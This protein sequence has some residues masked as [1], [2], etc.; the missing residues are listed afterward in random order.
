MTFKEEVALRVGQLKSQWEAAEEA[1]KLAEHLMDG[2]VVFPSIK[3]LRYAGRQLAY[4]LPHLNTEDLA[5][6]KLV[7]EQLFEAR[8]CCIRARHDAVDAA[9]AFVSLRFA[10]ILRGLHWPTAFSRVPDMLELKRR[11]IHVRK[12]IG[13]SRKDLERRE[14]LYSQIIETDLEFMIQVLGELELLE[15]EVAAN[16]GSTAPPTTDQA[17]SS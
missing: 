6:Q 16:N 17:A 1:A 12:L 4:A 8:Q 13:Q 14:D 11:L 7:L 15:I 2:I 9:S 5:R 3:E 10:E